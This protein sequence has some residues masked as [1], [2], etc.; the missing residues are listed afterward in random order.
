MATNNSV[1]GT[2][3]VSFLT[4]YNLRQISLH[5]S[6]TGT[7]SVIDLMTLM[8]EFDLYEDIYSSS[9]TGEIVINDALGL[10]SNY[11]L[12]GTEF[13]QIKLQK[14]TNDSLLSGNYRVYKISKRQISDS[15]QYEVY[16]LN[17]CS[18]ELLL[19]ENYRL[20]K[21]AKGKQIHEIIID[22]L[23]NYLKTKKNLYWEPTKGVYDFILP[24]KKL[25]E[26][27]NWL[28]TYAQPISGNGADMLFYENSQ[29]Y[30]FHSLQSLY[31]QKP[32]QTYKF[33]PKNI[34]NTPGKIDIQQQLT[35]VFDFEMLN[36]FDTL[37]AAS[38]GTFAN[39]VIGI[40]VLKRETTT[41]FFTYNNYT[42]TKLNKQPL[43]NSYQD[44]LKTTI[45]TVPTRTPAGLEMGVLR[46]SPSNRDNKKNVYVSQK[47]DSINSVAN[48][49]M[50]EKYLPNRVSQL[51][52]ANYMRLKITVAGDPNLMV[53][54][55][56]TFNTFGINP[57]TFSQTGAERTPDPL[58]SGNYLVTAV[59]HIIK[60]NGYI[61]VLEICKDSVT[62]S[63][64]NNN[65]GLQQ[66]IDG[67]Q[68]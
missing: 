64:S 37:D 9:I 59:R 15:N 36:F 61:T 50:L 17:F 42:G 32:Y 5:T 65:S 13:V 30:H 39:K 40:D 66:F 18:E 47:P 23:T 19:S 56:I 16:V 41:G 48:D 62:V 8:V 21:S 45:G 20:S 26:T 1:G 44:R 43:I 4:D 60:N 35:N 24:N 34:L 52:L 33:D 58:Y 67:V 57:V 31:K 51:A 46:M 25:F 10:I 63:Y 14:T 12:N 54:S 38:N 55:V 53:G 28:S 7:N 6:M 2:Q 11:L 49:I 29:G 27:I 3:Y 22:V 68:I